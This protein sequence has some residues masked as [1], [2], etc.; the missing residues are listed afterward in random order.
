MTYDTIEASIAEGRPYYLYQCIEGD[1]VWRFTSRASDWISATS[2]GG[3]LI[4]EAAA[5]SHGDVVQ[6]KWMGPH[7]HVERNFHARTADYPDCPDP[8]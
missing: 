1:A 8:W 6:G 3:Y 5:I 2:E 7:V 4:W